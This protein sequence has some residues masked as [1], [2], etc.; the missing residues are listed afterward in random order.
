MRC[1]EDGYVRRAYVALWIRFWVR[2]HVSNTA[3][4]YV[5]FHT[6]TLTHLHI[7]SKMLKK[8]SSYNSFFFFGYHLTIRNLNHKFNQ[9]TGFFVRLITALS[10]HTNQFRKDNDS[11]NWVMVVLYQPQIQMASGTRTPCPLFKLVIIKKMATAGLDFMFVT[12]L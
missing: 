8:H 4:M 7:T 9:F 11:F 10:H 3:L 1:F 6:V 12:P 5:S 2:L